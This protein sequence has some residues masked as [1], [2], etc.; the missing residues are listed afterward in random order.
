MKTTLARNIIRNNSA[1]SGARTLVE[2]ICAA[3]VLP[4]ALIAVLA[5]VNAL[6]TFVNSN[7]KGLLFGAAVMFASL[8]PIFVALV[9]RCVC[10]AIF[11]L[12]DAALAKHD[13]FSEVRDEPAPLRR[14]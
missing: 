14:S 4:S 13:V 7:F 9:M 12:A 3:T 6:D 5:A 10:M 2:F 1:Y 11:D 8:C